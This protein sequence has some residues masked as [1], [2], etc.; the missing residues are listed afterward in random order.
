MPSTVLSIRLAEDLAED[1]DATARDAGAVS[2]SEW[3]RDVL[4]TAV[5]QPLD[6][7]SGYAEGFAAGWADAN[8]QIREALREAAKRVRSAPPG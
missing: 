1:L 8:D 2:T 3:A 5:G 6:R 4:R 7:G